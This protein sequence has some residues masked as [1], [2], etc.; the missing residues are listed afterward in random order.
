[1]IVL[2]LEALAAHHAVYAFRVEPLSP[3]A[4]YTLL[5]RI[6]GSE[7]LRDPAGGLQKV[8]LARALRLVAD[9]KPNKVI[10]AELVLSERT[11]DR[12]V[13]S[14]LAKLGV[15]SRTAATAYA[16]AHQFV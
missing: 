3:Q 8:V 4:T 12:H 9:G 5:A 16:F 7:R 13:S 10:A 14:I 1:M 11:V 15:P 2:H 6:V